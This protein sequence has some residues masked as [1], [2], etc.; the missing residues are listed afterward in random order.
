[1]NNILKNKWQVRVAAL[2]VFLLGAMAGALAFNAYESWAGA[3]VRDARSGRAHF[4][5]IFDQLQLNDEQKTKVQ[6][7]LTDARQQLSALRKESEPRFA[8]VRRQTDERLQQTLTPDQW[9]KFQQ[10]KDEMRGGR[11]GKGRGG[12]ESSPPDAH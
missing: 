3:S 2:V 1:M 5:R 12:A 4:E 8:D 10:L 7:I 9:K 11:R 6:Q